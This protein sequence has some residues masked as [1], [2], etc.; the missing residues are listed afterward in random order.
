MNNAVGKYLA[1]TKVF[2]WST[3]SLLLLAGVLPL[4]LATIVA[5]VA[6]DGVF[7]GTHAGYRYAFYT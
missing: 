7:P 6:D 4:L 3:Q 2:S 5:L 1:G